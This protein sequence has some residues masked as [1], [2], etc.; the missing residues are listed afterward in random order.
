MSTLERLKVLAVDDPAAHLALSLYARGDVSIE[1]ALISLAEHAIA[2]KKAAL[3]LAIE[4]VSRSP[5]RWPLFTE[6]PR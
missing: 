4:T 3:K 5:G 6:W 2:A 1:E